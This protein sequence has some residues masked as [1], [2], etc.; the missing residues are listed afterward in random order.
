[1]TKGYKNIDLGYTVSVEEFQK[2]IKRKPKS[3]EELKTFA[4]Y[5]R[6]GMDAQLNWIMI[7]E[8][9]KAVMNEDEN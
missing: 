7:Y 6:Q 5:I 3:K 9:A 4:N 2:I 1:M 8:A